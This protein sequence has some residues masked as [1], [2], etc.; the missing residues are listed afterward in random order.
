MGMSH[1]EV[2]QKRSRKRKNIVMMQKVGIV[3][4]VLAVIGGGI[5]GYNQIPSV[6]VD[7]LRY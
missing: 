3:A 4:A 6:K 1:E 7:I 5:Y 2:R